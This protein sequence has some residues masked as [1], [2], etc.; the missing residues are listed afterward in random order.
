MESPHNFTLLSLNIQIRQQ[1]IVNADLNG[2]FHLA[3]S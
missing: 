3:V 2:L 1:N